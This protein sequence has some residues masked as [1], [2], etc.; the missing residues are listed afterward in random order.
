MILYTFR[1]LYAHRQE[2]ELYWCSIWYR[3]LIQWPSG[4]QTERELSQPVHRMAIDSEDDTRCCT[5]TIQLP[6]DEH[7]MLE[8]CRGL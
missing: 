2:A 4:A 7:T 8:T 3:P 1:A 6:D 5:N